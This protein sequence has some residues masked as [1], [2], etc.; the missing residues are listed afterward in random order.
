MR[1][2]V[3]LGNVFEPGLVDVLDVLGT[4]KSSVKSVCVVL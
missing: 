3:I 1:V 4:S 2:R